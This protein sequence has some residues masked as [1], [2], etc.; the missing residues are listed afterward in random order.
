[1]VKQVAKT[2]WAVEGEDFPNGIE[3]TTKEDALG[4]VAREYMGVLLH[5]SNPLPL[6][7]CTKAIEAPEACI[8][9][10]GYRNITRDQ[11]YQDIARE[12]HRQNELKMAGKFAYTCAD[13]QICDAERY[14]VLGEEYGE[15]GREICETIGRKVFTEAGERDYLKRLRAELIQVAAVAVAWV[16][17]IDRRLGPR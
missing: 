14:A 13:P 16:E 17:S 10:S 8:G 6:D 7:L 5:R 15:V 4:Y 12:R 1:M 11:I 9:S 2:V 3:F